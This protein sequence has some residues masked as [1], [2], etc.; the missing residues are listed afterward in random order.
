M[1][2]NGRGAELIKASSAHPLQVLDRE[3]ID[4]A[5]I[6]VNIAGDCITRRPLWGELIMV[7]RPVDH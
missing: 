2:N 4:V 1:G 6:A 7:A 5:I 3:E